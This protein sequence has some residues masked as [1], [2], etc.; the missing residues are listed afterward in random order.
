MIHRLLGASGIEA[1]A[2]GL[3]T[4][5]IG[6][7][8][9]G[10]AEQAESIRAIEASIG[11]GVNLIDTAP[12]YGLG[13]SEEVVGKAIRGKRSQVVLATKCGLVWHT[14]QG[15]HFFDED[16]TPVHRYLGAAS[17]RHEV[18]ESLRRL[19]TDY[20][21]L[22][23]THWQDA[24][25]P[26][27]ETMGALL[28]LKREGKIRAIGV[29]NASIAEIDEYRR[30]GAVD[31]DQE[32]YSMLDR[33]PEESKLPY[34]ERSGIAFLAYSPL[35]LGLLTGRI[36]ADRLFPPSDMRSTHPR[37]TS[38]NRA[39]VNRMLARI[40]PIADARGVSVA[41]LVLAWTMSQ[42]GATHVLAGARNPEQARS[43]AAAGRIRLTAE[44]LALIAAILQD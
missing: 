32:K 9:W 16:G 37:F 11:A 30:Q 8:L 25:T 12:V 33:G 27:A 3:G 29:S 42:P 7:W 19:G 10:G 28:D 34:L 36:A 43:N 14:R 22:Y 18:E 6:G 26:V 15:E 13:L 23:Q 17:V 5:A 24:T 40:E 31:T 1:S 21:D 35:A 41:Q 38:E 4:W 2:V 44:E 39:L 20:I